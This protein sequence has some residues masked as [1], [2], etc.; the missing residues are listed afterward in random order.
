MLAAGAIFF[1]SLGALL[2]TLESLGLIEYDDDK[3]A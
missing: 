1:V 2:F 3:E